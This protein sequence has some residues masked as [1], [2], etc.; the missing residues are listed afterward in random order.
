[1]TAF[2]HILWRILWPPFWVL[3]VLLISACY[4]HFR[5]RVRHRFGRQL[6]DHSTFMAPYNALI[7]LF[8]AVPNK[9][10]LKVEEFPDLKPL[11]DNW[12]IIRDE[13]KQLYAGGHIRKSDTHNDLA[14]N[15]FFKRGWTRFYL[16]WYDEMMPSALELCP[17]TVELVKSIPSINAALFASMKP[18]S[19][20]GEHR[21]PF[22][23][24]LRYHLGLLTPNSDECRIY[25]DGTPYSWRDGQAIL[26]DETY[27]HSVNNDTDESRIILFCDVAR[28]LRSPMMRAVNRF[29]VNHIVKITA[30]QNTETEKVGVL[31]KVSAYVYALKEFFQR[32]KK[33]NRRLYYVGKYA[34]FIGIFVLIFVLPLVAHWRH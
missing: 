24:S 33:A 22:A 14:F 32:I 1:M 11:Q 7:Y 30:T 29:V 18:R 2:W 26:F 10:I 17:K 12:E 6:T 21:D 4:I 19:K 20:L 8:S 16:K 34:L 15:T 25:V 13:A 31:N 9:P 5:G 3:G 23:G 27:I 28:P